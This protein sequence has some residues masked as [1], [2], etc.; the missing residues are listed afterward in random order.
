MDAPLALVVLR[1]PLRAPP[2]GAPST[3]AGSSPHASAS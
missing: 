2:P 1:S 3:Q